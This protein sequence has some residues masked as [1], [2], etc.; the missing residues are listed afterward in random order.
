MTEFI[1]ENELEEALVKAVND[2]SNAPAFYRQLS[3]GVVYFIE[4]AVASDDGNAV[5]IA[6]MEVD[7]TRY[8][9][10]FSSVV[11]IQQA[12]DD[13]V[14]Y[15]GVNGME[16]F[17][18]TAG[19]PI[20]LNPG[21]EYGK[22]ILADEA[23]AIVDGSIF[24]RADQLTLPKDSTY[25]IGDPKVYPAELVEALSAL[26][27]KS[28]QVKQAWLAQMMVID[29]ASGPSTLIGIESDARIREI[30]NEAHLVL[31]HVEIP[32]PPVDFVAVAPGS[33]FSD[34]FLTQ[35]PFYSRSLLRKLF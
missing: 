14:T 7:G 12:I 17:R 6:P 8:L 34:H 3:D 29:S 31:Q 33:E 28:K 10:I 4:Q 5:G 20:L 11:R 24:H 35:K 30:A 9:P 22:E 2:P 16:F 27:R 18:M 32:S 23:A 25:I 19:S 15:A 13:E 1:A 21:S 26:F